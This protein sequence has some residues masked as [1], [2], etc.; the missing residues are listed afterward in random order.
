MGFRNGVSGA[1]LR[2][3]AAVAEDLFGVLGRFSVELS[4]KSK[5]FEMVEMG[6]LDRV[7]DVDGMG[8]PV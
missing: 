4:E 2:F 1:R 7:D 3:A 6:W 5:S 8:V